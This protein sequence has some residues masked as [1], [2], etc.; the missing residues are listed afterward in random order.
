VRQQ[1]IYSAR[2]LR[3]QTGEHVLQVHNVVGTQEHALAQWQAGTP[4]A[5]V[6]RI[7]RQRSTHARRYPLGGPFQD[8]AR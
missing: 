8:V 5:F 4:R 2:R 6:N 7:E 1:F 3:R